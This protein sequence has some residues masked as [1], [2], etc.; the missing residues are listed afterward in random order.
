MA[1]TQRPTT[2]CVLR[3]GMGTDFHRYVTRTFATRDAAWKWENSLDHNVVIRE[4][5]GRWKK[6]A[7]LPLNTSTTP[8]R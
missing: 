3:N 5:P 8:L 4:V 7:R 1:T 6:G 2:I